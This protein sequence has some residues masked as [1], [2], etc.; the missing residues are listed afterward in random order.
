MLKDH[1][2]ALGLN[3]KEI[4]VYLALLHSGKASPLDV[5]RAT[6]INRTT[7]Y[8]VAKSLVE[9]GAVV[10]DVGGKTRYLVAQPPSHLMKVLDREAES[11]ARRK[12]IAN[13]AIKELLRIQTN[14]Q[15]SVPKIRFVDEGELDKH[16]YRQFPLWVESGQRYDN[17]C[18]GFQDHTFV[19]A[20][21][22]WIEWS[23]KQCPNLGTNL[24]SNRSRAEAKLRNQ[25]SEHRQ[26]KFWNKADKFTAT[27]WVIGDFLIMIMTNQHPHYLVE[28]NDSVLAHNQREV[29]RNLWDTVGE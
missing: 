26:I 17:L 15:Y 12:L 6:R 18:W 19:E 5:A 3:E 20:Y 11:I 9:K 4:E 16:L 10:E 24:L 14:T 28:I 23:W 25:L 29:F 21:R 13:E 7:V 27:T 8:S 1:L 2:H 22:D